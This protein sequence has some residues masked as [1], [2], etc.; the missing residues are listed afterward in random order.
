[1]DSKLLI[2]AQLPNFLSPLR[3]LP[4]LQL[5]RRIPCAASRSFHYSKD[6]SLR[7]RRCFSAASAANG[8]TLMSTSTPVCHSYPFSHQLFLSIVILFY[9][10]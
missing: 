1:M 5:C 3:K 10:V 8:S 2:V 4:C 6:A 7:L 9:F